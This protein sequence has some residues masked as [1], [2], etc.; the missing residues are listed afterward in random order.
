MLT[1]TIWSWSMG[2]PDHRQDELMKKRLMVCMLDMI[3]AGL[4][5]YVVLLNGG[6]VPVAVLLS[7]GT[8][9]LSHGVIQAAAPRIAVLSE[10]YGAKQ[11]EVKHLPEDK[12]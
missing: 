3:P 5:G 4:V 10:L 6:P 8:A 12:L 2:I 11:V 1:P 7:G 9:F